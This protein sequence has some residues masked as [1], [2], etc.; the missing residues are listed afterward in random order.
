MDSQAVPTFNKIP[1]SWT[2]R[3]VSALG[4]LLAAK[5]FWSLRNGLR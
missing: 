4:L 3:H 2:V 5:K 1:Q